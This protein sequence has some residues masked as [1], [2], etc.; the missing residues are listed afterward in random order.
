MLSSWNK[1][2]IIIIII[3]IIITI[4]I[5]QYLGLERVSINAYA[6]VVSKFHYVQEI[7]LVSLFSI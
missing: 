4:D 5:P 6:L 1:Y 7:G 3:I 2:I